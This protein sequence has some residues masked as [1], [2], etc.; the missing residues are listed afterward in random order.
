MRL[1]DLSVPIEHEAP[2]EA[3][4][5]EIEYR[6]HDGFGLELFK[7]QFGVGEEDLVYSGGLGRARSG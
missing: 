1:V 6:P 3:F 2:F 5:V 7:S 4:P